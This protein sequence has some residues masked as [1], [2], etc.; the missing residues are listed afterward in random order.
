[1]TAVRAYAHQLAQQETIPGWKLVQKK[2]RRKW[3]D[4]GAAAK[5]LLFSFGLNE[6]DIYET[7]LKSPAQAEKLLAKKDRALTE[8]TSLCP[9]VSTG[10]TLVHD[11]NPRDAVVPIKIAYDDGTS[12]PEDAEW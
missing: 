8:F 9:P 6:E 1:V 3:I 12:T 10:L 7:K 5:E 11:S 4:E 2:S